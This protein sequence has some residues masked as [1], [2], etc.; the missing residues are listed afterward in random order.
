[1]PKELPMNPSEDV[2]PVPEPLP[3]LGELPAVKKNGLDPEAVADAFRRFEER[4]ASLR[5]ELRSLEAALVEARAVRGHAAADAPVTGAPARAEALDLIRAAAEFA[6]LLERDGRDEARRRLRGAEDELHAQRL[7]LV[8]REATLDAQERELEAR[9]DGVLEEALREAQATLARAEARAQEKLKETEAA[10]AR[11]L[12]VAREQAMEITR[13]AR[14]EAERQLEWAR[15]QGESL[16]RRAQREAAEVR[17][18]AG[19][20]AP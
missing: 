10:G 2:K 8:E 11:L 20:P 5:D 9:R 17:T 12:E 7:K 16:L 3:L 14:G 15:A 4:I 18:L 13:E 1:V 6:E 19:A